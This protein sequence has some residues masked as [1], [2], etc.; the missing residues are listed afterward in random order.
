MMRPIREV[1]PY[2]K[3]PRQN[4]QAVE[5]VAKSIE[6][7]GFRV[8]IVVDPQGVI[9]AGHTRL[10][11]AQLLGLPKV[12]VHVA[13]EL[14]PEQVRA[15]R[16][17]DNKL[18]EL[19]QWDQALLVTELFELKGIGFDLSVLGFSADG[20]AGFFAPAGTEGLTD[21]D[22]VPEPPDEATTKPGDL[23]VLG[24]HRLLCGDS[25]SPKDV[26]RL[27][28]GV[29]IHLVNTDP[30]YNVKVEPRSNNAI[31]AGVDGT[32]VARL[33]AGLNRCGA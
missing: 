15:L 9:I 31:A 8:P 5:A 30:P 4:E 23:W 24:N 7:F 19:A 22:D 18:H 16:I 20:L 3:N 1:I 14:S 21:P 26:D 29:P 32:V 28:G 11:A 33:E 13:N 27:L 17:A 6:D 2:E 10:K 25:S 12:P